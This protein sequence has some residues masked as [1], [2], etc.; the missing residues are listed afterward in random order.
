MPEEE[1]PTIRQALESRMNRDPLT[2]PQGYPVWSVYYDSSDLR[3]YW[4][5][6]EGLKFRRKLRI[7]RYGALGEDTP[8][9]GKFSVE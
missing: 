7:R 3:F 9:D 1:I 5:K 6:I 8:D 4:E 2:G